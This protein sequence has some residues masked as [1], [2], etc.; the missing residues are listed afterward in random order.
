MVEESKKIDY[1]MNKEE[2]IYWVSKNHFISMKTLKNHEKIMKSCLS[3]W[4][5]ENVLSTRRPSQTT[6]MGEERSL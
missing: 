2:E 4:C 3:H 1:R 6:L 5:S